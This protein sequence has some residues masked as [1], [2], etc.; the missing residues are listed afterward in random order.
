[1]ESRLCEAGNNATGRTVVMR[2]PATD[3]SADNEQ[4]SQ[5]QFRPAIYTT[6]IYACGITIHQ[7]TLTLEHANTDYSIIYSYV[8]GN[9]IRSMRMFQSAVSSLYFGIIKFCQ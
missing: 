2:V 3:N 9:Y 5:V 7:A 8:T 6:W 4:H 1:M